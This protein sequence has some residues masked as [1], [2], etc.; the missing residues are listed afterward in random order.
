M[1]TYKQILEGQKFDIIKDRCEELF[2][3]L[4]NDKM[5]ITVIEL[6]NLNSNTGYCKL[7]VKIFNSFNEKH[8]KDFKE[9]FDFLYELNLKFDYTSG[10]DLDIFLS[11][12]EFFISEM[13]TKLNIKKFNI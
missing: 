1:I 4:W 6:Y 12:P 3:K 11:D 9:M 5:H 10:H 7:F 8:Y 2:N 13:E